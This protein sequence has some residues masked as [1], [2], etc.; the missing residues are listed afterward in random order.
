[1]TNPYIRVYAAAV[2]YLFLGPFYTPISFENYTHTF[3]AKMPVGTFNYFFLPSTSAHLLK[4]FVPGLHSPPPLIFFFNTILYWLLTLYHNWHSVFSIHNLLLWMQS[5]MSV[6][7][8]GYRRYKNTNY[9]TPQEV[10]CFYSRA[11]FWYEYHFLI[12]WKLIHLYCICNEIWHTGLFWQPASR[13][14]FSE[15][16]LHSILVS[17]ATLFFTILGQKMTLG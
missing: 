3:K 14:R 8:D 10:Y 12:T 1:M 6:I 7:Y 2:T 4:H 11:K 16:L 13:R 17:M 15:R 5:A 9:Y